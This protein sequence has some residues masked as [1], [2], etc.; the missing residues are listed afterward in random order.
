MVFQKLPCDRLVPSRAKAAKIGLS[1]SRFWPS[2]FQKDLYVKIAVGRNSRFYLSF[3]GLIV[4]LVTR[5]FLLQF[6]S[7]LIFKL[8]CCLSSIRMDKFGFN[9]CI[10]LMSTV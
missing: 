1:L 4:F 2:E 10:F 6:I 3:C 8:V 5:V 7:G 9:F